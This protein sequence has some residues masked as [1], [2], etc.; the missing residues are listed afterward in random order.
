MR[1][2]V[3]RPPFR[4]FAYAPIEPPGR[5]PPLWAQ[6]LVAGAFVCGAGVLLVGGAIAL[7]TW[8]TLTGR[9]LDP[10]LFESWPAQLALP[11]L[12]LSGLTVVA[13]VW[14]LRVEKRPLRTVGL[15]RPRVGDLAPWVAGALLA[16]AA[17]LVLAGGA[18]QAPEGAATGP[19][20]AGLFLLVTAV[21]VLVFGAAEEVVF[22]GWGMSVL[23]SRLGRPAA[24][25][26]TALIFGAVHVAPWE[27]A[28]PARVLG[29]V[30]FAAAGVAFGAV[31]LARRS[32][33]ASIALHGGYNFALAAL[34]A[35]SAGFDPAAM[36]TGA[37][38]GGSGFDALTSA[39]LL[40]TAQ[41]VMAVAALAYWRWGVTP[42][43]S[44]R[45]P[46]P[47]SGA[48]A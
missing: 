23:A 35:V 32:L 7:L 6:P 34:A 31:A 48:S 12:F 2:G 40:A 19:L 36:V 18:P 15:G 11:T 13:L 29:F 14:V 37:M 27:W 26:M 20:E 5:V 10:T 21:L 16:L 3:S 33:W 8:A 30:G 4:S 28:S 9:A 1:I 22:R 45:S 46:E 38:S 25:A 43:R 42:P 17:G 47:A 24:L 39:A 41:I 44:R